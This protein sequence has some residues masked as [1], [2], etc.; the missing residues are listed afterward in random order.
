MLPQI[1][2]TE[3]G[4]I[5]IGRKRYEYDVVI[6]LD[7]HVEKRKKSLSKAKYGTSHKISLEE[8]MQIYE[9]GAQ[10]LIIGTGQIGYVELSHEAAR[11]F[12]EKECS[13]K[14]VSTPTA[15][16]VWNVLEGRVIALFHVT[17]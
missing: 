15:A 1:V 11:F 9:E 5:T 4:N 16:K 17:C 8:A 2:K 14:L 7:G 13:V 6:R 3:F 12:D 10:E